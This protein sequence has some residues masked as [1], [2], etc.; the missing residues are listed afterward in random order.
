L[1]LYCIRCSSADNFY[2]YGENKRSP[3]RGYFRWNFKSSNFL[4]CPNEKACLGDTL[5]EKDVEE[6]YLTGIIYSSQLSARTNENSTFYQ[7]F[8]ERGYTGALCAECEVYYGFSERFKCVMCDHWDVYFKKI[9]ILLIKM[10]LFCLEFHKVFEYGKILKEKEGVSDENM[11]QKAKTSYLMKIA[12]DHFQILNFLYLIP[13]S[14]PEQLWDVLFVLTTPTSPELENIFSFD[15]LIK[16]GDWKINTTHFSLII[17]YSFN[18]FFGIS[19][20]LYLHLRKNNKIKFGFKSIIR[21]GYRIFAYI[22][23]MNIVGLLQPLLNQMFCIK[24]SDKEDETISEIR[25]MKDP[26]I[27][28]QSSQQY[29]IQNYISLPAVVFLGFA[30]PGIYNFM[31]Y[32]KHSKNLLHTPEELEKYGYFY[33]QYK[34]QYFFFDMIVY[35][36]RM[37]ILILQILL[38]ISVV[39]GR[40]LVV[41]I[42]YMFLIFSILIFLVFTWISPYKS[43]LENLQN[44][45]KSSA[46]T[47]IITVFCTIVWTSQGDSKDLGFSIFLICFPVFANCVFFTR[48]FLNFMQN[49]PALSNL[50]RKL[51]V[52]LKKNSFLESKN[53]DHERLKTS[54]N[55]ETKDDVSIKDREIEKLNLLISLMSKQIH[56]LQKTFKDDREKPKD[57]FKDVS[58]LKRT[59]RKQIIIIQH[60]KK[61]YMFL[62]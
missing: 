21:I 47:I 26:S 25:L 41:N 19:Y 36:K 7:G 6:G 58:N 54:E 1:N 30:V 13:F 18:F 37:I 16:Q 61:I 46:I 33:F 27:S 50:I 53:L 8:C 5:F 11:I 49:N 42:L 40:F 17:L 34:P 23:L 14:F 15:C 4:K 59:K 2:C 56:I 12:K 48:V 38:M 28:C 35:L 55:L 57:F 60:Q 9:I 10:I 62:I 22:I 51:K 52:K 44:F 31:N 24:I 20:L 39:E 29:M 45:E 43:Y 32:R 3:R